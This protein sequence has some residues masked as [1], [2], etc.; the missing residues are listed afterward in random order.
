MM[1]TLGGRLVTH[2]N[3]VLWGDG[4]RAG[5]DG[6]NLA[7][8]TWLL[9]DAARSTPRV[10]KGVYLTAAQQERLVAAAAG[11]ATLDVGS[12]AA[13]TGVPVVLD[14]A[15]AEPGIPAPVAVEVVAP[16]RAPQPRR[17]TVVP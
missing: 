4:A 2:M 11:A 13:L 17:L 8:G 15:P 12:L 5:W 16:G 10:A 3:K 7:V 1:C 9:R 14:D 6:T